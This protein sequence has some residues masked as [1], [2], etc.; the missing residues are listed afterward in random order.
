MSNSGISTEATR[1]REVEFSYNPQDQVVME[2]TTTTIGDV[3]VGK[4]G[5]STSRVSLNT[6]LTA[7]RDGSFVYDSSDKRN[8]TSAA[9]LATVA[10]TLSMFE[11]AYGSKIP[12][13]FDREQIT[14]N[15]DGGEML[16]A[17]Y[18]R[19]E[20]SLNFFH[21]TDPKTNE[22][23]MT[24]ASGEVVSHEVGHA[25]LDGLRPGFLTS[26][27]ADTNGF[28]EA[29]GDCTAMLLSTQDDSVCQLVANQTGGDFSKP[30]CLAAT[31][32]ELGQVINNSSKPGQGTGGTYIRNAINDLKWQDPSKVP[33][34]SDDR[35]ALT[36]E[37][38][39][40][41]RIWTG[42]QYEILGAMVKE[43]MSEGMS[44][45]EA[46]KSAGAET[47]KLYGQMLKEAPRNEATYRGMALGML[48]ADADNN[49]GKNHDI[50]L[51]TFRERNILS[52]TDDTPMVALDEAGQPERTVTVTLNGDEFGVFNGAEVSGKTGGEM[53]ALDN[54]RSELREDLKRLIDQG[55]IL[56]TEPNQ[57]VEKKDLFD[58]N[59]N[60]YIGV[61]RWTD[62]KM[63]IE[64]NTMI[65]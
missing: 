23:V 49:G 50:I 5:P 61:V 53:S 11:S 14:L 59:G 31:G 18:S 4:R 60:P 44:A 36:T 45:A 22:L 48:K 13:A 34:D 57:V 40:W 25:I 8:H 15:P 7:N 12:W 46:V 3:T 6:K 58:K 63:V 42:A 32:E 2:P 26:W 21:A 17:Y 39:S 41:S 51:N 24:G 1:A 56:Y 28:H 19:D 37:M 35:D 38:H 27:K 10:K 9:T 55:A 64:R 16:N 54:S 47:L 65:G 30:N 33:S 52:S 29:F 43:K 62:G 20:A